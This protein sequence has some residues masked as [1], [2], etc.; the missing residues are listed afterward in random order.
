MAD[1]VSSSLYCLYSV[2]SLSSSQTGS[3]QF[4]CTAYCIQCTV[5]SNWFIHFSSRQIQFTSFLF[6]QPLQ[7]LVVRRRTLIAACC[8]R[9]FCLAEQAAGKKVSETSLGKNRIRFLRPVSVRVE[10][11]CLRLVS[12]TLQD[13]SSTRDPGASASIG[14]SGNW[15]ERS[16]CAARGCWHKRRWPLFQVFFFFFRR[17]SKP[18]KGLSQDFKF[19]HGLLINHQNNHGIKKKIRGPPLPPQMGVSSLIG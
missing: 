11:W 14:D 1:L 2:Y 12:D 19:L 16:A 13:S 5:Q 8:Q 10:T 18:Q 15:S 4:S 9:P 17:Y 7:F 3:Q 6:M